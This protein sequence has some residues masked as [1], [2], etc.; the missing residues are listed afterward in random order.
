MG[1]APLLW[2]AVM[3]IALFASVLVHE[4]AH[5]WMAI[6]KGGK[7]RDITLLMIGGVSN[8]VEPPREPRGEAI[9]AFVGP[10]AS[11]LLAVVFYAVHLL[12]A[13]TA[14]FSLRFALFYLAAMN[15]SLAIFNLLPAFPMDGGRMLRGLLAPRMGLVRA[16]QTA[17]T[18]GKVFAGIFVVLSFFTFNFFLMIIAFFVYI[19]AEA[20]ARQVLA[21]SVLGE[22]RAQSLVEPAPAALDP[23]ASAEEAAERMMRERAL[24]LL[25]ET[26]GE[27]PA[28]VSLDDLLKVP[29]EQR[30]RVPV[31]AI[32]RPAPAVDARAS[33]WDALR[34]M[35]ERQLPM[36]PVVADGG[37]L[38]GVLQHDDVARAL[39]LHELVR[40]GHRRSRRPGIHRA[41]EA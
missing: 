15:F 27:G 14:L 30:S 22:I 21:K 39:R 3:A 33:V 2:G 16:T 31:A 35:S 26:D 9:M 28:V 36:V 24:A 38:V 32:A 18:I 5:T 13:D 34:V 8:V 37:Q 10:L 12:L 23:S 29:L 4:L 6:R 25:V 41:A 11:A 40:G 1:G 20:E 19:G 7:V 17:A